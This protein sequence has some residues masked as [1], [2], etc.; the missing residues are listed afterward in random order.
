VLIGLYL[1][2][3]AI[4]TLRIVRANPGL[5]PERA[6]LPL[7]RG[8]PR[9]DKVL[10]LGCM[11]AYAAE[12]MLTGLDH[13]HRHWA[14]LPPALAWLGLALFAAGW[15]LV[16]RALETNAFATMVV[17]HQTERGH[18]VVD[19]GVYRIVRHPMYAGLL[20]VLLG[21]PLWLRS[22]VGLLGALLPIGLLA[23]RI[24]LEERMLRQA[25]PAYA[26]YAAR[27]RSRI[28]PGLW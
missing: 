4:G 18:T 16:M 17:R 14:A 8:Q 5:L 12:L 10:L 22:P 1:V 28:V 25:L 23:L 3:H 11:A 21:V 15:A 6:K 19:W 2:V 9:S 24:V 26:E 20:G 7:Q 27:V 13:R